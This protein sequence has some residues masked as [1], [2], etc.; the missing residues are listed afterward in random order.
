MSNQW[1]RIRRGE[2][3]SSSAVLGHYAPEAINTIAL[4]ACVAGGARLAGHI[5][6]TEDL[7]SLRVGHTI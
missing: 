7:C 3:C 1:E 5:R 2:S 4:T 6:S